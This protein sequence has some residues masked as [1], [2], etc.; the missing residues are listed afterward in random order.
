[1]ERIY[2]K[3]VE[4]V[5]DGINNKEHIGMT[6]EFIG[7]FVRIMPTFFNYQEEEKSIKPNIVFSQ[8]IDAVLETTPSAMKVHIT[9]GEIDGSDLKRNLKIILPFCNVSWS[10]YM[11]FNNH[12][13]EYGIIRTFTG[14][15]GFSFIEEVFLLPFEDQ[16]I[17]FVS[18]T[19][20]SK[21][22]LLYRGISGTESIID[23]RFHEDSHLEKGLVLA[24][25]SSAFIEK[26]V[27]NQNKSIIQAVNKLFCLV[28]EKSHGS[29]IL[30]VDNSCTEL[31]TE[32]FMDNGIWL[33]K[34]INIVEKLHEIS[35]ASIINDIIMLSEQY[36]G[37]S[38]LFF[39]MVNI[40]GITLL[41]NDGKILGFNLFANSKQSKQTKKI[42]GGARKR[43][44]KALLS[45]ELNCI[46]GAYFQ[47]QDG[48]IEFQKVGEN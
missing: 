35:T 1:M 12:E 7:N 6:K 3:E 22:E 30:I 13:V 25:L 44:Y 11:N 43:A 18:M 10:L 48:D 46:V 5:F 27:H 41:S 32:L 2:F 16:E 23:F 4:S 21:F 47:S 45:S 38:G 28:N 19:L 26:S 17:S 33:S 24:T 42:V 14:I 20:L 39:E 36:Y 9:N 8:D 29:I 15:H 31:P 40:D 37:L 34:P